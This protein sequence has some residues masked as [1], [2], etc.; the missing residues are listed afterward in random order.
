MEY[1]I[2]QLVSERRITRSLNCVNTSNGNEID[3]DHKPKILIDQLL[4][5]SEDGKS[6]ND[7]E[8][9]DNIYAVI[10]GVCLKI[11]QN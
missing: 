4:S 3:D 11:N 9:K 5:T 1:V 7:T 8:I 10:T 2:L 6:F